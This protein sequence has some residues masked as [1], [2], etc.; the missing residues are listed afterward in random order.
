MKIEKRFFARSKKSIFIVSLLVLA[1]M[2]PCFQALAAETSPSIIPASSVLWEDENYGEADNTQR[3]TAAVKACELA[4]GSY[5][6]AMSGQD[7]YGSQIKLVRKTASGSTLWENKYSLNI[8]HAYEVGERNIV[9]EMLT[10][11]D[12]NILLTGYV[13][14][15]IGGYYSG[16]YGFL[17]KIN[18]ETQEVLW[19]QQYKGSGYEV[20]HLYDVIETPNAY[21]A[22]GRFMLNQDYS[23]SY[24]SIVGV[25]KSDGIILFSNT[26]DKVIGYNLGFESIV[27]TADGGFLAI[28]WMDKNGGV[29]TYRSD[30]WD[31]SGDED[32]YTDAYIAKFDAP[33]VDQVN[34]AWHLCYG[35]IYNDRFTQVVQISDGGYLLYGNF[36]ENNGG[37]SYEVNGEKYSTYNENYAEIV[38]LKIGA[39]GTKQWLE[40]YGSEGHDHLAALIQNND[41][42]VQL[43][44]RTG[45]NE[46]DVQSSYSEQNLWIITLAEPKGDIAPEVLSSRVFGYRGVEAY[47]TQNGKEYWDFI[48]TSDDSY[49][50]SGAKF[51]LVGFYY[52][53]KPWVAKIQTSKNHDLSVELGQ[54]SPVSPQGGQKI[55]LL[56]NVQ[57]LG[58]D[59]LAGATVTVTVTP[60]DAV[61]SIVGSYTGVDSSTSNGNVLTFNLSSIS[62]GQPR[63]NNIEVTT[64]DTFKGTLTLTSVCQP[65]GNPDLQTANN[66]ATTN[67]NILEKT[68][69]A[70]L[71]VTNFIKENPVKLGEYTSYITYE[72]KGPE[73]A[74]EAK[75]DNRLNKQVQL[76]S[77]LPEGYTT[78]VDEEGFLHVVWNLND[79][80]N[81]ETNY[82]QG[83][84]SSYY[85]V[86]TQLLDNIPRGT[87]L[88]DKLSIESTS[89]DPEE[90]LAGSQNKKDTWY[91]MLPGLTIEI[92]DETD[93]NETHIYTDEDYDLVVT[94]KNEGDESAFDVAASI[95]IPKGMTDVFAIAKDLNGNG[96]A[97]ISF[98]QDQTQVIWVKDEFEKNDTV[99]VH[100]QG[101]LKSWLTD[102]AC[103]D[104]I[105]ATVE[106]KSFRELQNKDMQAIDTEDLIILQPNIQIKVSP[107]LNPTAP[108]LYLPEGEGPLSQQVKFEITN[109]G[110][111]DMT[112]FGLKVTF[113]DP[114]ESMQQIKPSITG[115]GL[116][117]K[118]D[119]LNSLLLMGTDETE[120]YFL[121]DFSSSGFAALR[122]TSSTH[123][124][125]TNSTAYFYMDL[126]TQD[127]GYEYGHFEIRC[128]PIFY[129]Y[130][131]NS[132]EAFNQIEIDKTNNSAV[133]PIDFIDLKVTQF[134]NGFL[135]PKDGKIAQNYTMKATFVSTAPQSL[136]LSYLKVDEHFGYYQVDQGILDYRVG[137]SHTVGFNQNIAG[138]M[139]TLLNTQPIPVGSSVNNS[140]DLKSLGS[141]F[142]EQA[143]QD[144]VYP[145]QTTLTFKLQGFETECVKIV[146]KSFSLKLDAPIIYSPQ[147]GQMCHIGAGGELIGVQGFAMPLVDVE[148]RDA[149]KLL[150]TTV[151]ADGE[152]YFEANIDP[153]N[154]SFY[155]RAVLGLET[156]PDSVLVQLTPTDH[157]W[158]PQRT[159]W[160]GT[161]NTKE[162]RFRF[163]DSNTGNLSTSNWQIDGVYG[164]WD[165]I[166]TLYVCCDD[167]DEVWVIADNVKYLPY[168]VSGHYQYFH[169]NGAHNV[170]VHVKCEDDTNNDGLG[171]INNKPFDSTG[172]VLIDPDGFVYNSGLGWGHVVPGATVTCMVYDSINKNWFEWP[173]I[174]YDR[175]VNPQTVGAD[176]YF[177]FF[178][179]PGTYRLVVEQPNPYQKW[180]SSDIIVVSEIVHVN[181][182]YTLLPEAI[183]VVN[184]GVTTLGLIDDE[185]ADATLV[186]VNAGDVV[187]WYQAVDANLSESM[188]QEHY[189]HPIVRV[190]STID[191]ENDSSGFDSGL[192]DPSMS[193]SRQFDT[194]GLFTYTYLDG[195]I[196][197]Q[198]SI[199]VTGGS[200]TDTENPTPPKDLVA[201]VMDSSRVRLTWTGSVDS[202]GVKEY[203]V[204][205]RTL[206]GSFERVY[207]VTEATVQDTSVL[208][209]TD[210]Q[211][212]VQATDLAGNLS[213]YSNT[214]EVKTPPLAVIVEEPVENAT[215]ILANDRINSADLNIRIENESEIV[216]DLTATLINAKKTTAMD[217]LVIELQD[218]DI[219]QKMQLKQ[220]ALV[221]LKR[222]YTHILWKLT[223]AEVLI[224]TTKL[225]E[226]EDVTLFFGPSTEL[227][228]LPMNAEVLGSVYTIGSNHTW[229]GDWTL[230]LKAMQTLQSKQVYLFLSQSPWQ[231]LDLKPV[232]DIYEINVSQTS[233]VVFATVETPFSDVMGHWAERKITYLNYKGI[234]QGYEQG[235]FKPQDSIT[236]AEFVSTL[237]RI[238]KLTETFGVE[239]IDV[240]PGNWYYEEV[241]LA[242][243]A[244]II[245][246][247]GNFQFRPN[248]QITREEAMVIIARVLTKYG[249]S[250]IQIDQL[251]EGS[252]GQ[253]YSD[254]DTIS[255]W[256]KQSVIAC[257]DYQVIQGKS[258]SQIAPQD[259]LLRA[260][261]AEI[262]SRLIQIIPN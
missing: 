20:N 28:G 152:G 204:Y 211:Y 178:T 38:L 151:K 13:K 205:R 256:A 34:L 258:I 84:I 182:P 92:G 98:S 215:A 243:T 186:D 125:A 163:K 116:Q 121:T 214:V 142:L 143:N 72:N 101:K 118:S 210:Y 66:T 216:F 177:A 185:G 221:A 191:P 145:I 57:N 155:A 54:P 129:G 32:Q 19:K 42:T 160:T 106:G 252:K 179:P 60:A 134:S 49:L 181:V 200:V 250:E 170:T 23:P 136:P 174:A 115:M 172:A 5:V 15:S 48:P 241:K 39:D 63:Q 87:L 107:V 262:L 227:P 29:P 249:S 95:K 16:S 153:V 259:D 111:G 8:D 232:D 251:N 124:N 2:I 167:P 230:S 226:G 99:F 27:A 45:G 12:G 71:F 6:F 130:Y 149:Q 198:G 122:G 168:E 50:V 119:N 83:D 217:T 30:N 231:I 206:T 62:K 1:L 234:L 70:D 69:V 123:Q 150:I 7:Y 196:V 207:T 75:L 158:C 37:S 9:R 208:A 51:Y 17:L 76:V 255:P 133:Q 213:L 104:S 93:K 68:Y 135:N 240:L 21:V 223:G 203:F 126:T 247:D 100:I 138:R 141:V 156:S 109:L 235:V 242:S 165:S 132:A 33:A 195:N 237:V 74:K 246:G 78:T 127:G 197:K 35:T 238:L 239:Y 41:G 260:E 212:Y 59:D 120:P 162:Y 166:L 171:D 146:N 131:E 58:P 40:S 85:S 11:N 112:N 161:V 80:A 79:L 3:E 187:R 254:W 77:A 147:T 228:E 46:G 10:T 65:L 26:E 105:V 18:P 94:L 209:N 180:I 219:I 201:D 81:G 89:T 190:Q 43:L 140:L 244:R 157:S 183:P 103:K 224:D 159:F 53:Y 164:F 96:V 36:E 261:V 175:Q 128:E 47:L 14:R 148:I 218:L 114:N 86:T 88:L 55:T 56:Q 248:H 61:A 176:G 102:Q 202:V 188:L 139:L 73:L 82:I 22:V 169:I 91:G 194:A 225:P 220:E 222:A 31:P 108:Y 4:D 193:Y 233:Q 44:C 192:L 25:N 199:R 24:A 253:E 257:L 144:N 97:G 64:K 67:I 245:E 189:L 110:R 113:V 236:R 154:T 229:S 137:A 90:T 117:Q 52:Y 184:I 173:A